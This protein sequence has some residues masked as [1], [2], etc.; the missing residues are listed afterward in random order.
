MV[1]LGGGGCSYKQGTPVRCGGSKAFSDTLRNGSN[2]FSEGTHSGSTG[3]RATLDFWLGAREFGDVVCRV[4]GTGIRV[5]GVVLGFGFRVSGFGCRVSDVWFRVSGFGIRV[6][7]S[8]QRIER[9]P[10][11][12][13]FLALAASAGAQASGFGFRVSGFGVRVSGF[14]LW[15]VGY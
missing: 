4:P 3:S 13:P 6:S 7:G 2:D 1:V 10:G 9:S 14:G 15:V 11:Q 8:G 12:P 5:S